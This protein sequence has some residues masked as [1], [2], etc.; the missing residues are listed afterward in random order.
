VST[1]QSSPPAGRNRLP[2]IVGGLA[3][4][5]AVAG[6]AGWLLTPQGLSTGA[7]KDSFCSWVDQAM[8]ADDDDAALDATHKIEDGGVPAELDGTTAQP[9]VDVFIDL[10]ESVGAAGTDYWSDP[11]VA[12]NR[13]GQERRDLTAFL[14][15]AYTEC[16][17]PSISSAS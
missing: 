15:Y 5:L 10:S 9:G 11:L 4:V 17:A 7:D 6:A 12:E 3:V 13:T 16:G 2:L 8:T 14:Y 1:D